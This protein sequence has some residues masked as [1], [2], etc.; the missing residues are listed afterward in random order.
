MNVKRTDTIYDLLVIG[1]GVNGTA[2]ARDASGRGLKVLLCEQDDF[3][4][5]TSSSSTKL[6]HGGLRYLEQYHF[7]MV[8]EALRERTILQKQA[9]YLVRPLRF[10][11][12]S[13]APWLKRLWI[14]AGLALYDLLAWD[15]PLPKAKKCSLIED[16]RLKSFKVGFEYFDCQTDDSRLVITLAKSARSLGAI[17]LSRSKVERAQCI[18]ELWH[19]HLSNHCAPVKA[20]CLVNAT[21]PFAQTLA[22]ENQLHRSHELRYVKG[23]HIAIPNPGQQEGHILVLADKRVLFTVPWAHNT[24]MIGTTDVTLTSPLQEREINRD[25]INY[26]IQNYNQFYQPIC[27][28]DIIYSWAGVR[29]LVADTHSKA[30]NISRDFKIDL[31]NSPAPVI[32]IWGGKLTAHR[33]IAE[34]VLE[35]VVELGLTQGAPWTAN[36][37]LPGGFNDDIKSVYIQLKKQYAWLEPSLL[38]RLF[39]SYGLEVHAILQ[40]CSNNNDLGQ[41]FGASLYQKEVDYLVS[42]EWAQTAEDILWRRTKLGLVM[43]ADGAE[44]LSEYLRKC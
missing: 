7:G 22:D 34:K 31:V 44:Q 23:S 9:P 26:L 21:G 5:Y 42:H 4:Q 35:K 16:P 43:S 17:L 15:T 32:N 3:A 36:S 1:G 25:E 30:Q 8:K 13:R 33:E 12:P 14:R 19:C 10:I 2:I 11:L 38:E 40:Y 39:S 28:Q 20:K 18:D 24:L 6:I 41:H 27:S 37:I 29:P